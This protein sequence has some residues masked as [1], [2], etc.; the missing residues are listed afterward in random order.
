MAT[1]S[2][3]KVSAPQTQNMQLL[4]Y[5]LNPARKEEFTDF[6]A[7][8]VKPWLE[9]RN[10]T[11]RSWIA[12]NFLFALVSDVRPWIGRGGIAN[13]ENFVEGNWIETQK[14]PDVG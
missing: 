5:A 9:Q 1:T 11:A 2:H 14:L 10:I 4:T 7:K 8:N 6:F 13:L 3:P 12:G